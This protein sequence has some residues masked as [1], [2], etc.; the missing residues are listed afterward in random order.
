MKSGKKEDINL[1]TLQN[2]VIVFGPNFMRN[3]DPS[4]SLDFNLIS[5]QGKVLSFIL[6]NF[7]N[8]FGENAVNEVIKKYEETDTI[9]IPP[10]IDVPP[11]NDVIELTTENFLELVNAELNK[12][13]N[14]NKTEE[15]TTK[16]ENK[17]DESNKKEENTTKKESKKE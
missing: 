17:K 16:K 5:Q 3:P 6:E 9:D 15:N 8:I 12:K 14:E 1:M 13:K 2:L 11:P 4:N 7:D 10:P